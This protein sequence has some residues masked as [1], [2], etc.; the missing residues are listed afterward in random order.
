MANIQ[1]TTDGTITGTQLI[2]DG[3]E[4]TKDEKVVGI[5]MS[6]AAPY[7]SQYT[8]DVYKGHVMAAYTSEDNGKVSRHE[9]GSTETNHESGIGPEMKS[10]DSVIR[11]IGA[12]IDKEIQDMVDKIVSYCSE[13]KIACPN[14]E[15]LKSR[16]LESLKDKALD[17]G[18]TLEG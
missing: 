17:L 13:N 6:A 7:K 3:K 16:T 8:G 1:I 18:I 4:V 14:V 12:E 11:Y 5:Y 9:Y 15:V 2:V 10:D